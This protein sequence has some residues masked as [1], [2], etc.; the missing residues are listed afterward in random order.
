MLGQYGIKIH[1]AHRTF[2][3]SNEASGKAA[4][5]CVIIG[6]ANF[7]ISQKVLFEYVDITG[8]PL[9]ISAKNI[10]PYLVDAVDSLLQNLR[11][12]ISKCRQIVFGNM[13]ND[14]GYFLL[15]DDERK[16]LISIE[17]SAEKWIRPFL[18]SEE[19]IH[20]IPR[21]CL[22]LNGIS[23]IELRT[24]PE[25]V[26][27]VKAVQEVRLRSTRLATKK[28]ADMP[29]LFGE[30]RQPSTKF[31]AIPKTS[32]EKR[33]FIPI[34]FL[35][36]KCIPSTE[37]QTIDG[38][39]CFDFGILTSTMHMSWV[40]AV[41]GRLKSDFRYSNTIVYNNYPWPQ[42]ISE[43]HEKQVSDAAQ[44][45]LD[46]RAAFPES[47]LADLYDPL[48]MPPVLVKAHQALDKAVDA[49]YAKQSFTTDAQR[50]AFL[51]ALYQEITSLLPVIS[52]KPKRSKK[53]DVSE[54]KVLRH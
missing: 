53:V 33:K 48:A 8:E 41:C 38:A 46:A 50:V 22:W 44:A 36:E 32:S 49:C 23:P 25:V 24:M 29:T 1:F 35:D 5:H 21:W 31:L 40:R 14:D 39:S 15:N 7:D 54:Q 26:R 28:L 27:R 17:P 20:N 45:V 10:N 4:V 12:P 30:I 11:R 3:W 42:N 16:L 19:F 2:Q 51:F 43:K 13:P 52:S 37:L 47:S 18:G 34:G 9:A 6:F